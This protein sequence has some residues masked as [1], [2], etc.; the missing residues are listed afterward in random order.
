MQYRVGRPRQQWHQCNSFNSVSSEPI[1]ELQIFFSYQGPLYSSSL[2]SK[3]NDTWRYS[4]LHVIS[5][6]GTSAMIWS[7]GSL[8][9][10]HTAQHGHMGDMKA[11]SVGANLN[12]LHDVGNCDNVVWRFMVDGSIQ[13]SYFINSREALRAAKRKIIF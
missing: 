8:Y 2:L 7:C 9:K 5:D 3:F 10:A 11:S 1:F 6:V 13:T 12:V 4:N